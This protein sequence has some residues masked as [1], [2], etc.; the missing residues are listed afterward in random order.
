MPEISLDKQAPIIAAVDFIPGSTVTYTYEIT[1]TGNVTLTD[2]ITITDDRFPNPIDCG[3]APFAP[4]DVRDCQANYT[5]TAADENLGFVTNTATA[6][7]G[8]TVS[9][10]DTATVPQAGT[11]SITLDKVADLASVSSTSDLIT[12][13]FTVTNVGDLSIGEDQTI[14][15]NDP[16]LTNITC[17]QTVRIFPVGEGSPNAVICTGSTTPTQAEID[18]GEV[19]NTATAEF[20]RP[21]GGNPFVVASPSA[22]AV[23][24]VNVTPSFTLDKIGP[25]NFGAAGDVITY[26]FRVTNDTEQTISAATVTDPLIPGLVCDLTNIGPLGSDECTGTYTVTQDDVDAERIDNTATATGTSSTGAA[27][28]PETASE[29]TLIDPAAAIKSLSLSKTANVPSFANVGDQILFSFA[30]ANTGTQTLTDITVTDAQLGLSC[31]IPI[32]AVSSADD[33]SCQAVYTVT[34]ADIDAGE[35]VN[36]ASATAP[37]TTGDTSQSIVP[38]PARNADFSVEKTADD[39]TNVIEGQVVTYSYLVTNTGNVNL[40]NVVLTDTHNSASGA[41][42]LTI[43]GGGNTGALAPGESVTLTSSYT[44]TQDDIDA[45][46]ALTNIVNGTGVCLLYTSPSP[47]D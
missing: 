44:V 28:G 7:D 45:G 32:L 15:I 36:N 41:T 6:T 46:N 38:G 3:S 16:R 35:Y 37:D 17:D 4:G 18:A 47:R 43:S 13:T 30:V 26:T 33:A 29:T 2:P 11:D 21:N 19:E 10:A 22:Q 42:A 23:V 24:P 1:N 25:A 8:T 31:L 40:S 39:A 9:N 27:I 5:V 14:S 20:T 34:Q 12:Y